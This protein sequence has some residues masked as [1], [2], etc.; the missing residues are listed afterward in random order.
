MV[1]VKTVKGVK[2]PSYFPDDAVLSAVAYK[3]RPGD[4]FV[5]TYPKCG[6]TWAQ[7]IA[8]GIF[9]DGQ[10]P[11]DLADFFE[12]SP[13]M[14]L[15]GADVIEDMPGQ[16]TIKTHL[17]FDKQNFSARA[18]YIYVARN[19]YDVCVS[20]YYHF[21]SE[22]PAQLDNVDFG[23]YLRHFIDGT[24]AYGSYLEDSLLPWYTRRNDP[25]VLF[26]TY[27]DLHADAKLQV[28][29]IADML[30][31]AYG[32]RLSKD[33]A[34]LQ[35][36]VDMSS[37]ESMRPFFRDYLRANFEFAFQSRIRRNLPVSEEL[38]RRLKFLRENCQRLNFVRSGCVGGYK[39]LLS[40]EHK[41]ELREWISAKTTSSNVMQLWPGHRLP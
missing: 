11:R 4:V 28:K 20:A 29:R 7:Y 30:G 27:E 37:R 6:T 13:Y 40:E 21:K 15:F 39:N 18:K 2:V 17:P 26:L 1:V 8:Y 38:L 34:L 24:G 23:H 10:P 16:G 25:N 31:K 36:L 9:H 3:P 19:P 14:E 32:A 35:R 22:V 33:P 12:E 5:A 41:E